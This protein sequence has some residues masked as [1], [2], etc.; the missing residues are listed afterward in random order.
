MKLLL[1]VTHFVVDFKNALQRIIFSHIEMIKEKLMLYCGSL[2]L[3]YFQPIG[4]LVI[5]L[6]SVTGDEIQ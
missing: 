4:S 1:S 2:H 5:N 3:Q 6:T